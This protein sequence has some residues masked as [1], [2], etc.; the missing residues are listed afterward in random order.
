[1]NY[2]T[3]IFKLFSP[4][5]DEQSTKTARYFLRKYIFS[6]NVLKAEEATEMGTALVSLTN[7]M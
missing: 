6:K 5:Q 2:K 1:M 7:V 4:F 3:S